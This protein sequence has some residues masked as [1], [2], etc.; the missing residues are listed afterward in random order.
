[1]APAG[2]ES[3]LDL[4]GRVR[5]T[6]RRLEERYAGRDIIAVTHGGTIR[7]ALAE[8]LD[9]VPET[10]LAFTIDN[11]SITHIERHHGAGRGHK[12]R[13]VSVNQSPI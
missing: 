12:W 3:F 5:P 8:A 13:V 6:I 2:G 9:L 11:C 1:M 7:S 4:L 10:A